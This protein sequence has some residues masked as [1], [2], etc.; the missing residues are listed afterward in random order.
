MDGDH[1]ATHE[2]PATLKEALA[3][4]RVEL[5][6]NL[7]YEY[8]DI[9]VYRGVKYTKNKTEIDETDFYSHVERSLPGVDI[10]DINNY[11]CSIFE[12]LEELRMWTKFPNR[13]KAIAKG[14]IR[15][16]YGP[17]DEADKKTHI[18]LF[19]YD[20]TDIYKEFEVYEIWEENGL[21]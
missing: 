6:G 2:F 9:S 4:G 8:E 17:R 18:N 21:N 15:Q 5:P 12:D 20:N 11:S 14:I 10:D 16:Q 7:L 1:L 19:L 13:R 3:S